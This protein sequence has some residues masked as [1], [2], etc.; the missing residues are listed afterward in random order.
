MTGAQVGLMICHLDFYPS[1]CERES[2]MANSPELTAGNR[3][4]LDKINPKSYKLI[5][6]QKKVYSSQRGG[7]IE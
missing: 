4:A 1:N 3:E 6:R 5:T 7:S 2:L